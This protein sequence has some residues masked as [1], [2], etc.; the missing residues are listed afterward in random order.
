MSSI[1]RQDRQQVEDGE[2]DAD[3]S[4]KLRK[5]LCPL[6]RYIAAYADHAY[7]A[8][9]GVV[10][11]D[12][13]GHQLP[14]EPPKEPYYADALLHPEPQSLQGPIAGVDANRPNA[15]D[16]PPGIFWIGSQ[17]SRILLTL[18]IPLHDQGYLVTRTLLAD[19]PLK[20]LPA[21]NGGPIDRDNL[22]PRLNAHLCRQG[23]GNH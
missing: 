12:L 9:D 14:D 11:A 15:D 19:E 3:Q 21:I 23:T 17:S 13:T 1:E 20:V 16:R 5:A 7:R 6:R 10:E 18:A 2:V 8:R 4:Q 22:I